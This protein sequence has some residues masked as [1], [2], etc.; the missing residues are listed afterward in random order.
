MS[1]CTQMAAVLS[2]GAL[3]LEHC[4]PD[5]ELAVVGLGIL[6]LLCQATMYISHR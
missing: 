6:Q 4:A 1:A 2:C 5:L 3:L